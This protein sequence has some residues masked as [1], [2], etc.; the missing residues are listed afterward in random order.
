MKTLHIALAAASL[1]CLSARAPFQELVFAVEEGAVVSKSFSSSGSFNLEDAQVMFNGEEAPLDQ[2]GMED[3][4]DVE[5]EVE[6]GCTDTYETMGEVDGEPRPTVLLRAFDAARR[7]YEDQ[8]GD[9]EDE[10]L[11]LVGTTVRYAWDEGLGAYDTSFVGDEEGDEEDLEGL[12]EDMDLRSLLPE[13]EV[14][15][16]DSW[17]PSGSAVLELLIPG[18]D[19]DEALGGD[20]D[21]LPAPVRERIQ[22]MFEDLTLECTLAGE[23]EEDGVTL[24]RIDLV[25]TLEDTIAVDPEWI[26]DEEE[27]AENPEMTWD[28][29][30]A[31]LEF[32]LEGSVLWNAAE[33]RF[34]SYDCDLE[35]TVVV[36]AALALEAFGL[37]IEATLEFS[38]RT[39]AN[40][41]ATDG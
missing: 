7:A 28:H 12:R 39:E 16:G 38:M 41:S 2:I 30:D 6:M 19:V 27:E 25:A 34:Q 18:F 17:T 23:V 14:D 20:D 15:E 13:G 10:E 37:E 11:S 22:Q 4:I 9:G 24:Q 29:F 8:D 36:D 1:A 32:G 3:G 26:M 31:E 5:F 40:G 33:G 21:E 35:G